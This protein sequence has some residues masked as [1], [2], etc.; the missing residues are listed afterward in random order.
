MFRIWFFCFCM[1]VFTTGWSAAEPA[2]PPGTRTHGQALSEQQAWLRAQFEAMYQAH[3]LPPA[4]VWKRE[5]AARIGALPGLEGDVADVDINAVRELE[6]AT[7]RLA[8][9]Q[10]DHALLAYGGAVAQD[11]LDC[12]RAKTETLMGTVRTRLEEQ[13]YPPWLLVVCSA[14]EIGIHLRRGINERLAGPPPGD[15]IAAIQ[16]HLALVLSDPGI[17]DGMGGQVVDA[18]LGA[19]LDWRTDPGT[20]PDAM[21]AAAK[22][23]S[24]SPWLAAMVIGRVAYH[25][26]MVGLGT[27][28]W[29]RM[30]AGQRA[31][32]M[33]Q[34]AEARSA[35][36]RAWT[37]HP[38]HTAG[39]LMA[40]RT[41]IGERPD[42][43]AMQL[44][45]SR[46]LQAESD[47]PDGYL[48]MI[49]RL[50]PGRGGSIESMQL[51]VEQTRSAFTQGAEMPLNYLEG[52]CRVSMAQKG[53][54]KPLMAADP[55]VWSSVQA[56][57]ALLGAQGRLTPAQQQHLWEVYGVLACAAGRVPDGVAVLNRVCGVRGRHP[58]RDRLIRLGL[59]DIRVRGDLSPPAVAITDD[60]SKPPDM[61]ELRRR[62]AEKDPYRQGPVPKPS[63]VGG[64][65]T[66]SDF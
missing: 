40:L 28:E 8:E 59:L 66:T 65:K 18:A 29:T 3:P 52:V 53:W 10:V 42:L 21:L 63:P 12:N 45:L 11:I 44:W 56:T 47:S 7:R 41:H 25:R 32:C 17:A 54:Q 26:A 39:P 1:L 6:V 48:S 31:G 62:I 24:A 57:Y 5:T 23:P 4:S 34:L 2:A 19:C 49:E 22:E 46:V 64:G 50:D 61:D 14:R 36:T 9:M 43:P 58:E 30:T 33:A 15:A 55:A 35:F 60:H 27:V 51:I 13:A 20:L 16:R 37:L 38:R